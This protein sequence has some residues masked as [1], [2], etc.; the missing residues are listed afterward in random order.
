MLKI[1][2][3]TIGRA[4]LPIF[5]KQGKLIMYI[6]FDSP[7][8]DKWRYLS[9]AKDE[10]KAIEESSL[11]KKGIITLVSK[12]EVKE[13]VPTIAPKEEDENVGTPLP[14][15]D[16]NTPSGTGETMTFASWQSAKTYLIKEHSVDPAQL[17]TPED[18]LN[19]VNQLNLNIK[20]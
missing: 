13:E 16:D 1:Y 4:S 10:Q 20:F 9:S 7:V 17:A 11:Y 5:G 6:T 14:S 15:E 19:A 8:G 12:S 2:E 3:T 18:V